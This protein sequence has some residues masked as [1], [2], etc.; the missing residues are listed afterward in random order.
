MH[1]RKEKR[2]MKKEQGE[3]GAPVH[4]YVSAGAE[5]LGNRLLPAGPQTATHK[6]PPFE[7]GYGG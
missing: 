3:M 1:I 6:E 4:R 2:K 5:P 7:G